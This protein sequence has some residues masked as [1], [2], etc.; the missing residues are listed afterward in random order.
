MDG[1][2]ENILSWVDRKIKRRRDTTMTNP[3]HPDLNEK[4]EKVK[5]KYVL[6]G[7]H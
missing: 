5:L 4:R 1:S 6:H 3:I 2:G 7:T